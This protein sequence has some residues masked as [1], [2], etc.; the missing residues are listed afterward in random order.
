M[1]DFEDEV[2]KKV[3]TVQNETVGGGDSD[4]EERIESFQIQEVNKYYNKDRPE[5]ESEG[6][7]GEWELDKEDTHGYGT[8]KNGN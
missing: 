3:T 4:T 7:Q 6:E 8:E 2:T 5:Y 1:E